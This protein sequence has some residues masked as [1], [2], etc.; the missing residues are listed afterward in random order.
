MFLD[1]QYFKNCFTI[2]IVK[3]IELYIRDTYAYTHADIHKYIY[4]YIIY[5]Y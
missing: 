1:P 4:I 3:Y 5:L 2:N